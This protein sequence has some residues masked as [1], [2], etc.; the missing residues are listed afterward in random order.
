M[1]KLALSLCFSVCMF[2]KN[3]MWFWGWEVILCVN[4]LGESNSCCFGMRARFSICSP[5]RV[6]GRKVAQNDGIKK[7]QL[8][9]DL[10]LLLKETLKERK[11]CLHTFCV[12][13]TSSY[14]HFSYL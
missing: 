9:E 3:K 6:G 11:L 4:E 2:E 13:Q 8:V 10:R 5:V 7:I 14:N 1:K 12:T